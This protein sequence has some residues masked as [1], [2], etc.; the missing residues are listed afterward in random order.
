MAGITSAIAE[1]RLTEYLAAESAVLGNQAY[2]INGRSLT[3]ANLKDIREGIQYWQAAVER[4]SAGGG[5]VGIQLGVPTD[6]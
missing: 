5:G 4:L 1:A 2:T 6:G 3:R